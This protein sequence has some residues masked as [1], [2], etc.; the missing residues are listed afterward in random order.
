MLESKIGLRGID[1][2]FRREGWGGRQPGTTLYHG[3][4]RDRTI[5][6]IGYGHIGEAVAQRAAAFD[7]RVVGIRRSKQLTPP[8]LDW[9]GTP[10][11]L[12]NLLRES[13]FVVVACDLNEDTEGMIGAPQLALMKP[14]SVII[15]VARGR[16][17]ADEPLYNTLKNKKIGH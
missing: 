7:M 10:D 14:D 6:I 2:R 8:F 5:G 11:R 13:D 4:I 9:L 17:I 3:E 15:N 12:D 1:Q 16:V